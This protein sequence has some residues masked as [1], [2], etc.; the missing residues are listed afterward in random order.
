VLTSRLEAIRVKP[1]NSDDPDAATVSVRD[2]DG[3][4]V[5]AVSGAVDAVTAPALRS[6]ID[7]ALA[8]DLRALVID[9][10]NVD[11]LGSVGLEVLVA[12]RA[13]AAD[14][15]PIAVVADGPITRRPI[16]LTRV[17]EFFALHSTLE[18]ALDDL[19][20]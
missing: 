10:T 8:G 3:T 17:D 18:A 1:G 5:V 2:V 12:T 11:F 19:R 6:H 15:I 14:D 7:T 20:T 16:E 4:T 13:T 9:L